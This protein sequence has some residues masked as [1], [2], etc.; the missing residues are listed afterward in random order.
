MTARPITGQMDLLGLLAPEVPTV[1][2]G[3]LRGW[4]I[5]VLDPDELDRMALA[6][7]TAYAPL[8]WNEWRKF[9]GWHE[10]QTGR[11]LGKDSLHPSFTYWA[12]M[13]CRHWTQKTVA[14]RE[15]H[16]CQCVGNALLY[17]VYC[18][19]CDWWTPVSDGENK[20]VE[21]YLNHCWPGWW[22]LPVIDSKAK[23]DGRYSFPIPD[24][25]SERW[26]RPGAPIRDCRGDSPYSG[27]HVPAGSPFGGY[28]IA[29]NRECKNHKSNYVNRPKEAK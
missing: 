28:K 10:S 29:V 23:G 21:H 12:D 6:W 1:D 18:S 19:G 22:E 24:G 5:D 14:E 9:P 11:N 4:T 2:L 7:S 25:Y 8:P 20:A 13:R 16:P 3:G 17:R 26:K 15:L 27:R